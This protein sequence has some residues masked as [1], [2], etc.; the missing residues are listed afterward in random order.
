MQNSA[1]LYIILLHLITDFQ[2]M[3]S[4]NSAYLVKRSEFLLSSIE[5]VVING[6]HWLQA[7]NKYEIQNMSENPV[8][9]WTL[10]WQS[11]TQVTIQCTHQQKKV[12]NSQLTL[13][14]PKRMLPH[15]FSIYIW[16]TIPKLRKHKHMYTLLQKP[17]HVCSNW[18][19]KSWEKRDKAV[20]KGTKYM[21]KI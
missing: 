15:H 13:V 11:L 3:C 9:L 20:Y 1:F 7:V 14:F 17:C 16:Q 10:V 5:T 2:T 4:A 18:K 8:L 19:D 12:D 21:V 6:S